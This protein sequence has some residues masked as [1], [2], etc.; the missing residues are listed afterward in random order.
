MVYFGIFI[1]AEDV[2]PHVNW[3]RGEVSLFPRCPGRMHSSMALHVIVPK[4]TMSLTTLRFEVTPQSFVFDRLIRAL[5]R[6][7]DSE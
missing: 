1:S 6:F 3:T 5:R 4:W 7:L 2:L